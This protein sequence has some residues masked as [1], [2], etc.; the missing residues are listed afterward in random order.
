MKLFSLIIFA[1]GLHSCLR[2]HLMTRLLDHSSW[3]SSNPCNASWS[4]VIALSYNGIAFSE[5]KFDV[6]NC[7]ML[8]DNNEDHV[9]PAEDQITFQCN[10]D[11]RPEACVWQHSE[12]MNVNNP[13]P[14]IV[15]SAGNSIA[16]CSVLVQPNS[17]IVND[18]SMRTDL[19]LHNTFNIVKVLW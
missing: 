7:Q 18:F 19:L 6:T 12:P 15:C 10:F 16:G 2:H 11:G 1:T 9:L 4:C 17:D 13:E 14:D 8:P 5:G 3:N